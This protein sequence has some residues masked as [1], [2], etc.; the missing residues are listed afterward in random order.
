MPAYKGQKTGAIHFGQLVTDALRCYI[1]GRAL[2]FGW[3]KREPVPSHPVEAVDYLSEQLGEPRNPLGHIK[4]RDKDMGLDAVAWKPFPDRLAGQVVMFGACATGANW[5]GKIGELILHR[6]QNFVSFTVPP[7][8]LFAVP[9]VPE[10]EDWAQIQESGY[11]VFDRLRAVASMGR[12]SGNRTVNTWCR[13]RLRETA[14]E[15]I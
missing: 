12:W 4:A 5:R 14:A 15:L 6:W 3:P 1:G 2:R 8:L 10:E 13:K 7:A 9:W 11:I